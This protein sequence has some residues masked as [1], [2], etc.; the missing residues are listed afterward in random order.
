MSKRRQKKNIF[1]SEPK[2][3]QKPERRKR[4]RHKR[5]GYATQVMREAWTP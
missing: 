4:P 3:R 2:R 5:V 1:D